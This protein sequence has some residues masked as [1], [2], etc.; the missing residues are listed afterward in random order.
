[1]KRILLILEDLNEQNFIEVLLKKISFDVLSI[2]KES[3][4]N[5]TVLGFRP[6]VVISTGEG[7]KISGHR[8]V[9]QIKAKGV[10]P[11]LILLFSINQAADK[12]IT[13]KYKYDFLLETPINPIGLI[14]AICKVVGIDKDPV[15]KKYEKLP[16]SQLDQSADSELQIIS[17][18]N[19]KKSE[20]AA[21]YD[22]ILKNAPQSKENGFARKKVNEELQKIRDFEKENKDVK[23]IDEERKKFVSALFKK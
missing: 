16:I 13:S 15:I 21:K 23:E 12:S 11:K 20:R 6:D 17:Y 10:D 18:K 5:E 4:I 8:V 3:V 9:T 7:S 1:M 2:R 14:T 22:E 19:K